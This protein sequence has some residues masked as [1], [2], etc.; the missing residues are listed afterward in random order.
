M[1]KAASRRAKTVW[2]SLSVN[3]SLLQ[4]ESLAVLVEPL[5]FAP[6]RND[7]TLAEAANALSESPT[8]ALERAQAQER[9]RQNRRE[10]P[11]VLLPP[12]TGH[13][14]R[15]GGEWLEREPQCAIGRRCLEARQI[16]R[17]EELKDT[18]R[19]RLEDPFFAAWLRD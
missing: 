15:P 17:R 2:P 13:Q 3:Q 14:L 12:S 9:C 16:L 5:P 10:D 4:D 7:V 18:F 1:T 19:W 11:T 8:G 6:L